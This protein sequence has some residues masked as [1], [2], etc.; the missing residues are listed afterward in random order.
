MSE[1][2]DTEAAKTKAAAPLPLI[3]RIDRDVDARVLIEIPKVSKEERET[4]NLAFLLVGST[5]S[6]NVSRLTYKPQKKKFVSIV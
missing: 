3:A 5:T 4:S 1:R 6:S 2:E